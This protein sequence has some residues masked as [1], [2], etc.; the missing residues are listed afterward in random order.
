MRS[1]RLVDLG[2]YRSRIDRSEVYRETDSGAVN[3]KSS[4][5]THRRWQAIYM[6]LSSARPT[7]RTDVHLLDASIASRN[8]YIASFRIVPTISS[9]RLAR[10]ERLMRSGLLCSMHAR[11]LCEQTNEKPELRER[12]NQIA[13]GTSLL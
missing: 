10:S 11:D 2:L 6:P 8:S 13:A 9:Q 4:I 12:A 7:I 1:D 3:S 5:L